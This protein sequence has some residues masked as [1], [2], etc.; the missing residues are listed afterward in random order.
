MKVLSAAAAASAMSA[1]IITVECPRFIV[2]STVE[3]IEDALSVPLL[4]RYKVAHELDGAGDSSSV[5]GGCLLFGTCDGI[6]ETGT[7]WS[8]PGL[9]AS[10][11]TPGIQP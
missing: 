9:S 10:S 5:F 8:S 11:M 1:R 7:R 6:T 2:A 4:K 3:I